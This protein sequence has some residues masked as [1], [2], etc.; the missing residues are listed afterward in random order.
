MQYRRAWRAQAGGM[1]VG[2]GLP[3]AVPDADIQLTG[4]WASEAEAAGFDPVGAAGGFSPEARLS[5]SELRF[6]EDGGRYSP[7]EKS[8][9][10]L[11][12]GRAEF[13]AQHVG[14]LVILADGFGKVALSQVDPD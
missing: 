3:A 9:H 14:V 1:R 12:R 2:I 13:R 4:R 10:G 5:G 7:C 8:T 6:T 11:G